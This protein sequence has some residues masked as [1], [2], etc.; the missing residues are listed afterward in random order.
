MS[1]TPDIADAEP[2]RIDPDALRGD[3]DH[4][5]PAFVERLRALLREDDAAE[6]SD[7]VA[8]LHAA[9]RAMCSKPST[10]TSG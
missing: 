6:L 10:P 7:L 3:D 2:P 5:N 1:E 4:L 8:P 9:D